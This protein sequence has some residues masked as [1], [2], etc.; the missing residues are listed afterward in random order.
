MRWQTG[1][2]S[3]NVEDRRG[4]RIS[5]KVGFGG[6]A[7]LLALLV[8]LFFGA[9]LSSIFQLVGEDT[10]TVPQQSSSAQDEAADFMSVVLADTE[11]TWS[12][13]FTS[14]GRHYQ[15][16]K[17]V[18]F[19]DVVHSACGM[20]QAAAGP[21][22]CPADRKVYIDLTFFNKLR[23]MGAQGDF[24]AAYVLAHEVGHHVQNLVGTQ[25]KV[26]RLQIQSDKR[27]TNALSVMMELQ[28]DCYA[29]IWAHHAQ[30]QRQILEKGDIEEG[31]R[32]AAAVGDDQ[33]MKAAGRRVYPDAFTHGSSKQR[34]Q[35]FYTG[36]ETG[37]LNAC[38]TF[39]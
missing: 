7:G 18:L 31:L 9:D 38:N 11:D 3:R 35:W 28:A 33:I 23:R 25:Q 30:R 8:A 39:R 22:Y 19:S 17:L 26:R 20:N 34:V 5:R 36:F 32:A 15:P 24:A 6:G 4:R 21:F 14:S 13:I 12:S 2:R 29:G 16:P 37:D 27:Q 1:R 10:Q